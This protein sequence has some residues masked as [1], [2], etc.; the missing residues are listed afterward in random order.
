MT[1]HNASVPWQSY[2]GELRQHILACLAYFSSCFVLCYANGN[3]LF[4]LIAYPL[5]QRIEQRIVILSLLDAIMTPLQLAWY[6]SILCSIPFVFYR[7]W[8]F[9]AP[10]LYARERQ[11]FIR[12]ACASIGLFY[13][14]VAFCMGVFMPLIIDYLLA[15]SPAE[16]EYIAAWAPYMQLSLQLSIRFGMIFECPL[17][18]VIAVRCGL[19]S[20]QTLKS[21][22]RFAIVLAFI[23]GM[24]L[25]PPDILSQCLLAIPLC[26]LYES[27]LLA[28]QCLGLDK[29]RTNAPLIS[30]G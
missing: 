10:A 6:T 14:G 27:G 13:L 22:R 28:I 12:F 17:L 16:L 19:L 15:F 29:P 2:W 30:T 11:L 26:L 7:S 20:H 8:R 21:H 25:T 18:M 1:S 5:Q 9:C 23:I 4:H 24:L 3:Q